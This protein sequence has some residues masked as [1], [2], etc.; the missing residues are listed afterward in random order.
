MQP[1]WAL[2]RLK[3]GVQDA[4]EE[5]SD[6]ALQCLS[7]PALGSLGG[8]ALADLVEALYFLSIKVVL[9]SEHKNCIPYL[10]PI[11]SAVKMTESS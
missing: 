3:L 7:H 6:Q 4:L 5:A 10:F 11:Q 1:G 8:A 9:F 2:F